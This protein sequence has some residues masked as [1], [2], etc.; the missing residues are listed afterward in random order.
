MHAG[1][2]TALN[3]GSSAYLNSCRTSYTPN[4]TPRATH[5]HRYA[6]PL[7]QGSRIRFLGSKPLAVHPFVRLLSSR[8]KTDEHERSEMLPTKSVSG[9]LVLIGSFLFT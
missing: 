5:D 8:H 3:A 2:F 1:I 9:P 6:V 7:V 4:I